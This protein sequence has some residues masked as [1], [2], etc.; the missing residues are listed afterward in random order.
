MLLK[1]APVPGNQE[2]IV[3]RNHNGSGVTADSPRE[4]MMD[5]QQATVESRIPSHPLGVKPLGNQYLSSAVNARGSIGSFRVLPDEV[6]AQLLEY[7][8][9]QSLRKLGYTCRFLFAFCHADDV[10]KALFLE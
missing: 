7:F 1:A 9:Q 3:L 5:E 8:G 4:V 10:W 2:D 6:L